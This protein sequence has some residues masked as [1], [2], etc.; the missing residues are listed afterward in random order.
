MDVTYHEALTDEQ[1]IAALGP[2]E[3]GCDCGRPLVASEPWVVH[4]RGVEHVDC[5]ERDCHE[6]EA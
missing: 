4:G 1:A 5:H 6:R 2:T 3:C